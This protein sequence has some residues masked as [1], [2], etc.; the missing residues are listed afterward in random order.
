MVDLEI[1]Y[2]KVFN[3]QGG[4]VKKLNRRFTF[5]I[6]FKFFLKN[7]RNIYPERAFSVSLLKI[8]TWC[9]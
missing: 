6:S 3:I 5:I 8:R 2:A 4:L 9:K 7:S 1:T